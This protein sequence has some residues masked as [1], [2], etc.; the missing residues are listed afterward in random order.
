[1]RNRLASTPLFW[2]VFWTNAAVLVLAAAALAVGPVAVRVPLTA[3]EGIV[4]VLGL[5]VL[6]AVSLQL[7]RPAFR[8][9]DELADRMRRHDPFEAG[10]HVHVDGG[11]KVTALAN[12][13]NE[14]L[15]RLEA[16]R[17]ASTRRALMVQE[18]ERE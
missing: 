8:P 7:L 14:M 16:E 12:T 1:M 13:F 4:L 2:R 5:V 10:E 9:F 17:R 15:D 6:L 18:G 11:P 3:S